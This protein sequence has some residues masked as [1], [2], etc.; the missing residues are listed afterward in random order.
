MQR[1]NKQETASCDVGVH[2]YGCVRDK[3]LKFPQLVVH[4]VAATF[5]SECVMSNATNVLEHS[6]VSILF[7]EPDKAA[8]AQ[9]VTSYVGFEHPVRVD[10]VGFDFAQRRDDVNDFFV[11]QLEN[12]CIGTCG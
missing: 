1:M 3:S 5:H 12:D 2:K 8:F 9:L 11:V 4:V 7:H 10:P 6:V